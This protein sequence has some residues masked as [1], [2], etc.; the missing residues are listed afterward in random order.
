MQQ[1]SRDLLV[2]R[3]KKKKQGNMELTVVPNISL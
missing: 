2:A 1:P 3:K